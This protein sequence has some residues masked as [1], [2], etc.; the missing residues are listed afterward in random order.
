MQA[1]RLCRLYCCLCVQV[2]LLFNRPLCQN[3]CLTEKPAFNGAVC[4]L[5]SVPEGV[6]VEKPGVPTS[7][8]TCLHSL[9]SFFNFQISEQDKFYSQVLVSILKA[10][11][12]SGQTLN[13]SLP[14]EFRVLFFPREQFWIAHHSANREIDGRHGASWSHW[15]SISLLPS[16]PQGL[17]TQNPEPVWE[18]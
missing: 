12:L 6:Q 9:S 4:N 8:P 11:S 17:L 18:F 2:G 16:L 7:F 5:H 1:A 14:K 3:V 10:P 15:S 13:F